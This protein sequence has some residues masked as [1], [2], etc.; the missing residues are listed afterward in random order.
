MAEFEGADGTAG[1]GP[2]D[3]RE[4]PDDG[5]GRPL[6]RRR[7]R[8]LAAVVTAAT[9]LSGGGLAASLVIRSPARA[10]SESLPPPPDVLTAPVERRV[11]TDSVVLRGQVGAGQSVDV[12]PAGT[13]GVG[14]ARP[15]VTKLPAKA[16]DQVQAGQSVLEVAG[17]PVFALRGELPVY[18]DLKPGAT[19]QDVRQ[20][21][22]ALAELGFASDGDPAGRYGPAT[23][24]AVAAFYAARGYDP[25][26]ASPDGD[27]RL[28]AAQDAVTGGERALEDAK[29]ALRAARKRHDDALAAQRAQQSARAPEPASAPAVPPA[30]PAAPSDPVAPIAPAAPAVPA[31]PAGESAVDAARTA[32]ETAQKQV[33]R[34]GEDLARLRTRAADVTATVG[35]MVPAGELLFL[36]D[37]PA[38]VD[39]V[40]GRIGAEAAGRVLTVSAGALTVRGSLAVSDKGLVHPGQQ[41]EIFSELTGTKAAA[42]VATVADTPGDD[43][44]AGGARSGGAG[45]GGAGAGGGS[46]PGAG[47]PGRPAG[48]PAGYRLVVQPDAP[49]DPGLAGQ[50][51]RLTVQAAS[52]AGPVLVVP[53][54]AVSATADGRTVVTVYENGQRRRVEVAPGTVGGGSAEVR[55]L[56]EDAVR[57]GDRVIVGVRDAGPRAGTR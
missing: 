43:P 8:L 49:L 20:L 29:D 16:G 53:L 45:P 32:V 24:A 10:A 9:V 23:K 12:A 42:R 48:G 27:A 1:N 37:F 5:A 35:P 52:S 19:G 31:V 21:Q 57:P 11:L 6:L 17:R 25:L 50:D 15:V 30:V 51:V 14:S 47:A 56:V 4:P 40:T 33:T 44:P 41:V 36:A 18:R 2:A 7:R 26:P 13:A 55:P 22:Q 34:A 39:A 3:G 38:R 46:E 54:S 28:A